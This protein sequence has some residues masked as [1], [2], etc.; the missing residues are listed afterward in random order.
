MKPLSMFALATLLT[1]GS[2]TSLLAQQ[3]KLQRHAPH[4]QLPQSQKAVPQKDFVEAIIRGINY[5]Q[6]LLTLETEIGVMQ[7]QLAPEEMRD[8]HVGDK[9]RVRMLS[10]ER[11]VA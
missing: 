4:S 6:G 1:L 9:V 10:T 3:P 5:A 11:I 8:L 2:G 7:V